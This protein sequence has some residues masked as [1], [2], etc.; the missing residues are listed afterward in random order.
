MDMPDDSDL[1]L[2]QNRT[3]TAM[4]ERLAVVEN[5]VKHVKEGISIIRS[6]TH[7]INGEMQK[8]V[9]EEAGCRR[10]LETIVEQT[11]H[12]PVIAAKFQTFDEMRPKLEAVINE[13]VSRGG[14]W[15]AAGAI[16]TV[17]LGSLTVLGMIAGAIIWLVGIGKVGMH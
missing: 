8:F 15:R 5:E 3:T 13:S 14:G 9:I 4:G 17:T 6:T 16:A 7:S 1:P 10:A 2:P 12:L 11:K